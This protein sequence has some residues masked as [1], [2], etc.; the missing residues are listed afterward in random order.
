[1][2]NLRLFVFASV[3]QL[4]PWLTEVLV[5]PNRDGFLGREDES[6]LP[7]P[8][9]LPSNGLRNVVAAVSRTLGQ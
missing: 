3:S 2:K 4:S 9:A 5:T 8:S 7:G 1:L 6:S